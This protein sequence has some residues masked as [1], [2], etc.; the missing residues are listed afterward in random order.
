[1]GSEQLLSIAALVDAGDQASIAGQAEQR[2]AGF[3][4]HTLAVPS[5]LPLINSLPSGL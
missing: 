2:L 4:S 3:A 1:M 5:P